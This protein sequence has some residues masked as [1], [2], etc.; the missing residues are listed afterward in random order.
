MQS[1]LAE[2]TPGKTTAEWIALLGPA[3]IPAMRVNSLEDLLED[4]HLKS[5]GMFKTREHPT[6]GP[7]V[8]VRPPVKFS[9]RPEAAISPAPLIGEHSAEVL[10]ELMRGP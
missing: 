6:E 4:P 9:A 3:G 1:K 8:E 7:Y 2:I 10:D 5:V